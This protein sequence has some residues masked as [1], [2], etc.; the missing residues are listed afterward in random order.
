[1]WPYFVHD[2]PGGKSACRGSGPFICKG[3]VPRVSGLIDGLNEAW[4]PTVAFSPRHKVWRSY[5][6]DVAVP[7]GVMMCGVMSVESVLEWPFSSAA[8]RAGM[9]GGRSQRALPK[10]SYQLHIIIITTFVI[11]AFMSSHTSSSPSSSS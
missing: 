1:M 9:I 5:V 3:S 10:N 6:R 8:D 11:S 4:C 7:C 2:V